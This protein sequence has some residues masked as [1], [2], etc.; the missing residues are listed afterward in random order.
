[1]TK[2]VDIAYGEDTGPDRFTIALTASRGCHHGR[3]ANVIRRNDVA[4]R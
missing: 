2:G 3:R 4:T 1:M